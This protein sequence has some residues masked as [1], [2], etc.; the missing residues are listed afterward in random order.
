MHLICLQ[1]DEFK[2][3]DSIIIPLSVKIKHMCAP[4]M[5]ICF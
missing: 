3:S 5:F 2:L 1:T 4:I